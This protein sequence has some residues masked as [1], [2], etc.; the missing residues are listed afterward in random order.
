MMNSPMHKK[1]FKLGVK[2]Y[3][4]KPVN[5]EEL[6]SRVIKLTQEIENEKKLARMI[7]NLHTKEKC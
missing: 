3:L 1:R 5:I 4:L 6:V 7:S 2:D